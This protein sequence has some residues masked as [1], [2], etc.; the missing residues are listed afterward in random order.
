MRVIKIFLVFLVV[1]ASFTSCEAKSKSNTDSEKGGTISLDRDAFLKKVVDYK[2]N[3]NEWFYLGDKPAIVDFYADWCTPC[4]NLAPILEELADEYK[5]DI[6]IYKVNTD[7]QREV[8]AAFGIRALPTILFIP[9]KG[10]PQVAQGAL[11]KEELKK[12]IESIL[13]N[14]E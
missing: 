11:P 2:G 1:V 10:D 13:L 6:Y 14:N 12:L 3:P 5:N 7:R 4:R 9:L 8:A